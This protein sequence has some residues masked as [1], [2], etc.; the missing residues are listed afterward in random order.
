M[1]NHNNLL[2]TKVANKNSIKPELCSLAL[3]G[4]RT[5]ATDS[6]RLLEVSATGEAHAPK[7]IYTDRIKATSIPKKTLKFDLA[8][9][10]AATETVANPHN[11]YPD[12]DIILKEDTSIEYATVKV[13][14]QLLGELLLAMS[15]IGKFGEVEMKVPVNQAY[16]PIHIYAHDSNPNMEERQTAHGLMMPMNR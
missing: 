12:V 9:L 4:N 16:K 11:Q 6:F 8:E 10:E 1:Y 3:Y 14:A 15:K 2:P 7:I 13:N 5:V